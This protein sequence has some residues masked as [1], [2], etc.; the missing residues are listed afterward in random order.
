MAS[1]GH[2][3]VLEPLT[4]LGSSEQLFDAWLQFVALLEDAEG[5]VLVGTSEATDALLARTG[6]QR[7]VEQGDDIDRDLLSAADERY[8]RQVRH[9]LDR[10]R[11]ALYGRDQPVT[12]WWWRVAELAGQPSP[13]TTVDVAAAATEKRVHPHTVRSAINTGDLPARRIGR[14]FLIDRRDLARW[15]PR[16]VGRP[17]MRPRVEADE[18]LAAFNAANE[19]RDLVR[20][21]ALARTIAERPTTARRCLAVALDAF[22][23]SLGA[24]E[25]EGRALAKDAL[26]WVSAARDRGLDARGRAVASTA[27]AAA[28]TR[29]GQPEKAIDELSSLDA[30]TELAP[31]VVSARID[32]YL[33]LDDRIEARKEARRALADPDVGAHGHYL[34]ARVEF[35]CGETVRALEEIVRYRYREPN[36]A[37]GL[38]LHGSV[39]GRLGDALGH[40]QLYSEALSLFRRARALSPAEAS[41]ASARIGIT[42]ARLGRW[43][44]AIRIARDLASRGDRESATT[45][46]L[47]AMRAAQDAITDE[48][49]PNAVRLGERWLP[50]CPAIALYR[51]VVLGSAGDWMAASRT[52]DANKPGSAAES[53]E[54]ALVR[55][56]ALVAANRVGDAIAVLGGLPLAGTPLARLADVLRLRQI[57]SNAE[58]GDREELLDALERLSQDRSLV[59]LLARLWRESEDRRRDGLVS[60][61]SDVASRP[62][63]TRIRAVTDWDVEHRVISAEAER[64]ALLAA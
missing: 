35:H 29:L 60:N 43:R 4:R 11:V 16:S 2:R 27:A 9:L 15:Q 21:H 20:A 17:A 25:D 38:M 37:E 44:P 46:A 64:I 3:A 26:A 22:N 7:K 28:L 36:R 61:V 41:R 63:A 8:R 42:A 32:A 56:A 18:L 48:E 23:R 50:W 31:A 19:G 53:Q 54:T 5:R 24:T 52:I 40:K 39:L 12:D 10:T 55:V 58:Q 57:V 51:A 34:A 6:L 30:P 33:A 14:A 47:A 49:F 62:N 13:A 45:V 1:S 59:G